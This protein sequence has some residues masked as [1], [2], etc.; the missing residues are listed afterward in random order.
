MFYDNLVTF[1]KHQITFS[2]RKLSH[3]SN[4]PS[5]NTDHRLHSLHYHQGPK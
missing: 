3:V 5:N 2:H 4:A 1:K